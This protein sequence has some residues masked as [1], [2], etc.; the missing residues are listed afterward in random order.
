MSYDGKKTRWDNTTYPHCC[1]SDVDRIL[2]IYDKNSQNQTLSTFLE[3]AVK[4]PVN[5]L[6]KKCTLHRR[7]MF[8]Y[9]SIITTFFVWACLAAIYKQK[10]TSGYAVPVPHA[11]REGHVLWNNII[12]FGSRSRLNVKMV[13]FIW[14]DLC[15]IVKYTV[16]VFLWLF[17][18]IFECGLCFVD[19]ICG[20][21]GKQHELHA[22]Y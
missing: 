2:T 22:A 5:I 7:N 16:N 13:L 6:A 15:S 12:N 1:S 4:F 3:N 9:N 11:H 8:K 10:P 18:M 17:L 14:L 20:A 21:N 19:K